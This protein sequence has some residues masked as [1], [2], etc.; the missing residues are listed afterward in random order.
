MRRSNNQNLV[1]VNTSAFHIR[2][3][4][5]IEGVPLS[6]LNIIIENLEEQHLFSGRA[7]EKKTIREKCPIREYSSSIKLKE[8][9]V[10]F[11]KQ[12]A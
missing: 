8:I 5:T 12:K 7:I 4:L 10:I 2:R 1:S 9:S 11:Q 3:F 6:L